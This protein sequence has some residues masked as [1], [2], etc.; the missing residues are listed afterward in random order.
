M[1]PVAWRSARHFQCWCRVFTVT[2]QA[3]IRPG[4]RKSQ[5]DNL[6]RE[7]K[8]TKT[9]ATV[10][11]MGVPMCCTMD[12]QNWW[13]LDIVSQIVS[14]KH[15]AHWC[16]DCLWSIPNMWNNELIVCVAKPCNKICHYQNSNSSQQPSSMCDRWQRSQDPHQQ[17][18][19]TS[20]WT[21]DK[22]AQCHKMGIL[23]TR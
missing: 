5:P 2:L 3:G 4:L 11:K 7:L 18:S 8:H 1:F 6:Q 12:P 21:C 22:D 13:L 23:G 15:F 19:V 14:I 10:V 16:I 20:I 9:M 17:G